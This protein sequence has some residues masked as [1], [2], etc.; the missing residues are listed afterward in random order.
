MNLD[1]CNTDENNVKYFNKAFGAVSS[2]L[3]NLKNEVNEN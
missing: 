1:I 3:H 2:A